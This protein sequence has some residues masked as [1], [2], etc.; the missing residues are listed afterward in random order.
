MR[1]GRMAQQLATTTN[2]HVIAL[3]PAESDA[4]AMRRRIL[5]PSAAP[6]G[7]LSIAAGKLEEVAFPRYLADLIVAEDWGSDPPWCGR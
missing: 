4:D 3:A 1:N 7:R 2:L 5:E 6:A